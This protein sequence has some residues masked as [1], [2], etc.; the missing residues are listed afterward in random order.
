MVSRIATV[1]Q[2]PFSKRPS[3]VYGLRRAFTLAGAK[4]QLMSLWAVA[5]EATKDLMVAYYQR[6]KQNQARGEALRQVQLAMLN[7]EL[8]SDSNT[9]YAHPYF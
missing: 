4:S 3:G 5:D 8:R 7:G 6:L 9:S 1:M 2:S